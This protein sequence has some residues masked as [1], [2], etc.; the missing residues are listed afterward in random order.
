MLRQYTEGKR[1][2]LIVNVGNVHDKVDVVSKV[3]A[4]DAAQ[5]V[6]CYV[7]PAD[8]RGRQTSRP[9]DAIGSL[10]T[11]RDPCAKR[12]RLSGHNCT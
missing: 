7:V 1:T 9:E 6:L 12:R 10:R 4:Q 8:I 2:H 5:E 11:S 3:V